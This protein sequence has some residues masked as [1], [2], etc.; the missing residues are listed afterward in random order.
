VRNCPNG[1]GSKRFGVE[2]L[3]MREGVKAS[4]QDGGIVVDLADGSTMVARSNVSATGVEWRRLGL[5]K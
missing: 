4:F 5:A 2:V 3:M 1:R